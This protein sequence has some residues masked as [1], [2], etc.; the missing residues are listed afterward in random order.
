M[1]RPRRQLFRGEAPA[2]INPKGIGNGTWVSITRTYYN[3]TG[4]VVSITHRNG[5]T[6]ETPHLASISQDTLGIRDTYVIEHKDTDAALR[7]FTSV[8]PENEEVSILKEAYL[9]HLDKLNGRFMDFIIHV[10]TELTREDL[11]KQSPLY[12]V[13]K[14]ISITVGQAH[15]AAVHPFEKPEYLIEYFERLSKGEG[16]LAF[17]IEIVDNFDRI[18]VRY[19]YV[20][21]RIMKVK[22]IKDIT[23]ACGAY[24]NEHDCE[25]DIKQEFFQLE[26][27]EKKLG[28][29]SSEELA[30]SAGDIKA[31]RQQEINQLQHDLQL[32]AIELTN[33]QNTYKE[34]ELKLQQEILTAKADLS[35]YEIMNKKLKA[36]L[37]AKKAELDKE[38][39]HV[40][41]EYERKSL[42]DRDYYEGRSHS[43]KD[44]TEI[45]KFISPVVIGALGAMAFL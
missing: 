45:W 2:R 32:R 39:Q 21:N 1:K 4:L 43:R 12:L 3:Y 7:Y 31:L 9:K 17:T 36:E 28:L 13:N 10:D 44:T 41:A 33:L 19:L 15:T 34:N 8:Q 11:E 26:E 22:P 37:D 24:F 6:L 14:D 29:Y 25:G 18:G 30:I 5:L 42:A 16:G 35:Q 20:S 40:K 38:M 27:I 23:R